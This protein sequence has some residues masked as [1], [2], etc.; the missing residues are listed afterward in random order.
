MIW[1]GWAGVNVSDAGRGEL[2]R[3]FATMV[4]YLFEMAVV[5]WIRRI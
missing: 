5:V 4:Y 3:V 1:I 2:T